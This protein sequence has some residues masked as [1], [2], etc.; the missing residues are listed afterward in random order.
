MSESEMH[1]KVDSIVG[2]KIEEMNRQA[3]ED[4]DHRLAIEVKAKADSIVQSHVAGQTPPPPPP[5]LH[6]DTAHMRRP[7]PVPRPAAVPI[8]HPAAEK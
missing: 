6:G 5:G 8:Q 7:I 2:S 3:M 1:A 4:L